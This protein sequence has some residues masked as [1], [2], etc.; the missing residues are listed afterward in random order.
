MVVNISD[1]LDRF[2]ITQETS[3]QACLQRIL[4]IQ[5]I[6]LGRLTLPVSCTIF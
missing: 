6:E 5:F 4:L 3:L 1:Q 2:Y